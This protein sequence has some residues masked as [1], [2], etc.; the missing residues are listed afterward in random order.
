LGEPQ[1][2]VE[3]CVGLQIRRLRKQ[4]ETHTTYTKETGFKLVNKRER[5]KNEN[6]SK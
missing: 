6:G 3:M 1:E 2:K 4:D 5:K